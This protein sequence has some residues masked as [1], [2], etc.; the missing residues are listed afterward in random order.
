MRRGR[1]A[2]TGAPEGPVCGPDLCGVSLR[3]A[4]GAAATGG[5]G[6]GGCCGDSCGAAEDWMAEDVG[7]A[8]GSDDEGAG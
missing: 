3:G 1:G 8:A 5:W 7:R 2:R 4:D 6:L